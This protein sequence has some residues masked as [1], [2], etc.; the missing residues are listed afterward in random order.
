[1]KKFYVFIFLFFSL[2]LFLLYTKSTLAQSKTS[3]ENYQELLQNYRSYQ[4]AITP[5]NTKKSRY[6]TY[7]TVDTQAE[8]LDASKNLLNVETRVITSYTSFIKSLL[9]EATQIL[10]Y[11]DTVLYI[12]LD[13]E[14]SSLN[15]AGGKVGTLSS[16]SEAETLSADFSDQ[17][18]KISR[19]GYQIKSIVEIESV[20]KIFANL[21]VEK[22]KLENFLNEQTGSTSQILAAK[23]KFSTLNQDFGRI[24]DLISQAETSQKKLENGDPIGLTQEIWKNLNEAKAVIG[25]IITGYQNIIFSLK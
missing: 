8:L 7:G 13:D 22:N 16:L 21:Q 17:Y 25:Q 20:K 1:M 14:L 11:R 18:K 5:F 2:A 10:Q 4:D 3:T 12:K 6:L 15:I 24:S 19:I 23:E 9:A